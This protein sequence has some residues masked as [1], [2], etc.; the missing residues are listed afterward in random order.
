MSLFELRNQEF[1]MLEA[2]L[3]KLKK[4]IQQIET[5]IQNNGIEGYYSINSDMLEYS[6]NVYISMK[7]LG[8]IKNFKGEKNE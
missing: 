6:R 4:E 3:L 5:K 8:Y 7:I 2:N 1:R